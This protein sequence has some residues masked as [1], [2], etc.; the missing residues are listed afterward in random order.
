MVMLG[1]NRG[2]PCSP[3]RCRRVPT[4]LLS[5]VLGFYRTLSISIQNF[6]NFLSLSYNRS[7][8]GPQG[9][10]VCWSFSCLGMLF[11]KGEVSE[12]G[13]NPAFLRQVFT[14]LTTCWASLVAQW[15]RTHLP[16]QKTR[17]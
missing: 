12:Q 4:F 3:E 17:L 8:P 16:M 10:W 2:C 9:K 15:Q 5:L 7:Y 6:K 1:H 13:F 14:D 11:F